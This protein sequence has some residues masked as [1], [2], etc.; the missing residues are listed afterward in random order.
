MAIEYRTEP[1]YIEYLDGRP[2]PK[3]SPRHE[4][5][6]VQLRIARILEDCAGERGQVAT[7]LDA[8]VGKI[9][10]TRSKLIPDVSYVSFEQSDRYSDAELDEPPFAP[11]IA[12]E[13]H[14]IGDTNAYLE[15]KIARYLATG[16]LLV[17]DVRPRTRSITAHAA[18]DV[19]TFAES[20]VFSHPAVPWL[21][22]AL[23][24][25]FSVLDRKRPS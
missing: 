4:H 9:D 6:F 13:V 23:R 24:D 19:R 3:V 11:E 12:V 2:H 7:E 22:F 16:S 17:L 25:V 5:A 18:G 10:G 1:E 8:I 14:S 21:T 15:D 20:D